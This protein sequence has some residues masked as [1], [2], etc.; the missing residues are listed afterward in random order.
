MKTRIEKIKPDEDA[1]KIIKKWEKKGYRVSETKKDRHTLIVIFVKFE[2]EDKELIKKYPIHPYNPTDD[3]NPFVPDD[4][5]PEWKWK[6]YEWKPKPEKPYPTDKIYPR[7]YPEEID[8]YI[9]RIIY[10]EI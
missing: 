10:K 2:E 4:W 9:P 8:R 3:K 1:N 7:P 5:G 6:K